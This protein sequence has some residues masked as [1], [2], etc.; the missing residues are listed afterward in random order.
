MRWTFHAWIAL[1]LGLLSCTEAPAQR[2][3]WVTLDE[4]LWVPNPA[5]D[6]DSFHARRNRSEYLLRLYFVDTPESD[7]RFPDRAKEQAEYFGVT[8]EQAVEGGKRAAEFTRKLL[9]KQPFDIYT[10]YVDARG[11]SEQKRIFA[12]VKVQGQWLCEALVANGLARIYGVGDALPDGTEERRHW[13]RLRTLENTAKREK[14]GLWGVGTSPSAASPGTLQATLSRR[15]P[16]LSTTPP[17]EVTGYVP[18]GQEVR[19]GD[20]V[21]MGYRRVTFVGPDGKEATG[22]IQDAFLK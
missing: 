15:T 22:V 13:S 4:T 7:A 16:I 19:L 3:N 8:V 11:A 5:N 14:R 12:M 17:F 2:V 18:A 6:G 10:K 1:W 21:R 20:T 9:E